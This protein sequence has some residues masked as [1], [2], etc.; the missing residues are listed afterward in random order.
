MQDCIGNTII[1]EF[2]DTGVDMPIVSV[3]SL[4]KNGSDGSQVNFRQNG[5]EVVDLFNGDAS[6]FVKRRG[7][8]FMKLFY[9]KSQSLPDKN[10]K[11]AF[12]RP[13][14]D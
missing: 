2:E 14:R 6:K 8:Y 3:S 10:T 12:S 5:G 1:Q 11:P 9:E 4:S 7:V 13:G